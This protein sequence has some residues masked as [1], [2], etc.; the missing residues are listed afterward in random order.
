MHFGNSVASVFLLLLLLCCP[1]SVSCSSLHVLL[2]R[3]MKILNICSCC[4]VLRVPID[5]LPALFCSSLSATHFC[6]LDFSY[7]WDFEIWKITVSLPFSILELCICLC[8]VKFF[9]YFIYFFKSE[10]CCIDDQRPNAL[11][12]SLCFKRV[13][14]LLR[15]AEGEN[16]DELLNHLFFFLNGI[17]I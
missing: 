11:L 14:W 4:F 9:F 17:R 16:E 12:L 5:E 15:K 2:H 3:T 8:F 13:A 6:L 1:S 10:C 7:L